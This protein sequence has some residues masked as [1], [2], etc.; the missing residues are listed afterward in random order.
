MLILLAGALAGF[1]VLSAILLHWISITDRLLKKV[2]FLVFYLGA[3]SALLGIV[4]V[5]YWIFMFG[6]VGLGP[7]VLVLMKFILL[8]KYFKRECP[9]RLDVVV[10]VSIGFVGYVTYLILWSTVG[11]S[12]G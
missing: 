5:Q 12:I 7:G 8:P 3:I 1:N 11:F 6:L 10:T 2:L 4:L 9:N